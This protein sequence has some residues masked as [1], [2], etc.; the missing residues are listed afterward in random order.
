M[1]SDV[2]VV[3]ETGRD[4]DKETGRDEDEETGR[5]EDEEEATE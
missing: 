5:D 2:V 3:E 4:E 1:C